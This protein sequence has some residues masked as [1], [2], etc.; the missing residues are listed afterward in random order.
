[1]K[2][3][4]ISGI[5]DFMSGVVS[6]DIDQM[7][8][9]DQLTNEQKRQIRDATLYKGNPSTNL[10]YYLKY[11]NTAY[12]SLWDVYQLMQWGEKEAA[13]RPALESW[14]QKEKVDYG[15]PS[16]HDWAYD[17]MI[18]YFDKSRFTSKAAGDILAD[19]TKYPERFIQF[20]SKKFPDIARSLNDT[21]LSKRQEL[22]KNYIQFP[23]EKNLVIIQNAQSK[24][25]VDKSNSNR[26]VFVP[27]DQR[28]L[29][30]DIMRYLFSSDKLQQY[31]RSVYNSQRDTDWTS[32]GDEMLESLNNVKLSY[33]NGEDF[34]DEEIPFFIKTDNSPFGS[35]KLLF[36]GREI[37][38]IDIVNKIIKIISENTS[39]YWT[40][41]FCNASS[42]KY[43]IEN[44]PEDLPDSVYLYSGDGEN[45]YYDV[46]NG[47]SN[48]ATVTDGH[49]SGDLYFDNLRNAVNITEK[50]KADLFTD[51]YSGMMSSGKL[52][53]QEY[54]SI[55]QSNGC[56]KMTDRAGFDLFS[57]KVQSNKVLEE[58]EY[59]ET[60]NKSWNEVWPFSVNAAMEL[61]TQ[62]PMNVRSAAASDSNTVGTWFLSLSGLFPCDKVF[63][64]LQKYLSDTKK[65]VDHIQCAG[66][67][68]NLRQTLRSMIYKKGTEIEAKVRDQMPEFLKSDAVKQYKLSDFADVYKYALEVLSANL[69]EDSI[70]DYQ[71]G[72]HKSKKEVVSK[73]LG[74]TSI[75]FIDA[76]K[77]MSFL[78]ED[79]ANFFAASPKEANG[80]FASGYSVFGE[81]ST[82]VIYTNNQTSLTSSEMIFEQLG[83]DSD[84][85]YLS[86]SQENTLWH[87]V[88][89]AFLDKI[90]NGTE[91][92]KIENES[93]WLT[94]PQEISAMTYGN[95]QHIKKKI[96]AY[97]ESI[98][99]FPDRI[100]QGLLS[101][102]KSDIVE[103][104]AWEFQGM[105]KTE[106]LNMIDDSMPEFTDEA[107]ETMNNLSKEEQFKM[108]TN[109]F[110][111]FFMRKM[112][113]SKVEDQIKSQLDDA[114]KKSDKIS[115][116]EEQV[117]PE[118]K[119]DYSRTT[120]QPDETISQL[121]S[122]DDYRQFLN[123]C[124][125]VIKNAYGFYGE[126]AFLNSF[127]PYI[128]RDSPQSLHPVIDF[129]DL[130]LLMFGQP[131]TISSANIDRP[132]PLFS[133]VLPATLLNDVKEMVKRQRQL[134]SE[135]TYNPSKATPVSP[136]EAE[137]AGQFMTEMDE[138]YGTDWI[139]IAKNKN[140]NVVLGNKLNWYRKAILKHKS[141]LK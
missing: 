11:P 96:R 10:K 39:T 89:H 120:Y 69:T 53:D 119:E 3:Y 25:E 30:F 56:K 42:L 37:V 59:S 35:L 47:G 115:F 104:F 67:S 65:V 44:I 99:P 132:N 8:P 52:T 121:S 77:Y 126:S 108:M 71:S 131:A 32:N 122:R 41:H 2:I 118:E 21:S 140:K 74:E 57:I 75:L 107:I 90:V 97:F 109:M 46:A 98:Y 94:S 93:Q 111:E 85:P 136:Q 78:G 91:R 84:Q 139:W 125:E 12:M 106:A 138:Q 100:T 33:D 116:N 73:K 133:D 81:N 79:G 7:P 66:N 27:Q 48:V 29:S 72:Q 80:F 51:I 36:L 113:R 128:F 76:V 88:S 61:W 129:E 62:I 82:I 28:S 64:S 123:G 49:M 9:E 15:L 54:L 19:S 105:S 70:Y 17:L 137:D 1:M 20:I 86:L 60:Y 55:V 22:V 6:S 18:K 34:Y 40:V 83:I 102:I 38:Q 58:A 114:G 63:N 127:R 16:M 45:G 68:E 112:M 24:V 110:T 130:L 101:Q 135:S 4:K 87:E 14:L 95:L 31:T 5:D 124:Q 50:E 117:I 23:S 13:L 26:Y 134:L 43:R 141:N 103:T 92:D